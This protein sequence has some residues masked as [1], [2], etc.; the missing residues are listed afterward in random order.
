GDV[1]RDCD[2]RLERERRRTR[3][4]ET[5]LLRDGG[6]RDDVDLRVARVRDPPC[7][8]QRDV[9]AE[10]VVER[11]GDEASG[12]KLERPPGPDAGIADADERLCV[13]TVAGADV[14][15][16]IGVLDSRPLA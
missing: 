14:D 8:L 16:Q 15:V 11:T 12:R 2:V 6:D 5:D 10:A 7:G 1:D 13:L 3:A 9:R 4:E